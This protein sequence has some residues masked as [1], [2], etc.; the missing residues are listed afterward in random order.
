MPG[1]AGDASCS[2][3]TSLLAS[4]VS[5]ELGPLSEFEMCSPAAELGRGPRRLAPH[6]GAL[7][8]RTSLGLKFLHNQRTGLGDTEEPGQ[9]EAPRHSVVGG[10]HG[11]TK[12]SGTLLCFSSVSASHT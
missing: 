7:V 6:L 10:A 4:P 11:Q 2:V 1:I 9:Q 12:G 3:G 5:N 8:S